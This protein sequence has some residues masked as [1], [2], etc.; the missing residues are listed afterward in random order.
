[1]TILDEL[2]TTADI[3]VPVDAA[4]NSSTPGAAVDTDSVMD[5][6]LM[7][8]GGTFVLLLPQSC[9]LNHSRLSMLYYAALA[10]PQCH[11]ASMP[12]R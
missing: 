3:A 12:V 11:V 8:V 10:C 9:P 7:E 4:D 1:M 2:T 6:L 5:R